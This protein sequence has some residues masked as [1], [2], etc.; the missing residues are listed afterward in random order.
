M[1]QLRALLGLSRSPRATTIAFEEA[2]GRGRSEDR[3]AWFSGRFRDR[4]IEGEEAAWSG[5]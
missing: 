1:L 3:I 4:P 5:S 2:Q